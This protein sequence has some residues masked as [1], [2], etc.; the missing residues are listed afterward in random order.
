[1][2]LSQD[3]QIALHRA[4]T[5]PESEPTEDTKFSLAPIARSNMDRP[6]HEIKFVSWDGK[7]ITV[8]AREGQNLMQVA[9]DAG[10]ESVEGICGG[11]LEV[12]HL[13][14]L[15]ISCTVLMFALSYS[16]A[17]HVTCTFPPRPLCHVCP[18]PRT[19]C[20]HTRSSDRTTRVGLAARLM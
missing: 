9:K 5:N 19:T 13:S 14:V 16:S 10:L 2:G 11:N 6:M 15:F 8:K 7:E 20:L 4:A 17:Q 3:M 1:M 18:T 12:R